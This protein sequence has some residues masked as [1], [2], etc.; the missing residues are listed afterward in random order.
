MIKILFYNLGIKDFK[1]ILVLMMVILLIMDY[2]V[3]MI[4][5]MIQI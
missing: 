4:N 2:I 5:I 1:A 3:L